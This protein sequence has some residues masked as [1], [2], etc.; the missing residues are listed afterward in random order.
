[1]GSIYFMRITKSFAPTALADSTNSLSFTDITAALVILEKDAIPEI[2][3]AIRRFTVLAPN[4]ATIAIAK[5]IN[6]H[7]MNTSMIRIMILSTFPP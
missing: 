3:R 7:A 2:P 4:A 5:R 6:G 1:M